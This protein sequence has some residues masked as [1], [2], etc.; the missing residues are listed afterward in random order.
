MCDDNST[1]V[2][3]ERARALLVRISDRDLNVERREVSGVPRAD[4]SAAKNQCPHDAAIMA[5]ASA[6]LA[7]E[8]NALPIPSATLHAI[9]AVLGDTCAMLRRGLAPATLVVG[10]MVVTWLVSDVGAVDIV[11]FLAYEIGF[12]ALPGAALLW[13]LRGRSWGFLLTIALGWPLGQT[14]EILAYSTTAA[15]GLRGLFL[16]YPVVV[17]AASAPFIWRRRHIG[18]PRSNDDALSSLLMWTAAAVL[19]LG[20]IYLALM[21]LPTVPLPST[22]GSVAYNP[23]YAYFLGLIAEVAHHWPATS[24]GLSGE[25]LHYQWF[26]FIHMAAINQVTNIPIPTIAFRLDYVPTII[27]LGCQLLAVGRFLGK[28]AWTGVLATAVFLLLG[29]LDLTTDVGGSTPFFDLVSNHL[30]A[31]W[32]FPYGLTFFLALIYCIDERLRA[33]TWR[34]ARD[35]SSWVLIG[36]LMIGGSGAKGTILPVIIAGLGLYF[37]LAFVVRRSIPVAALVTLALSLVI[38][39]VTFSVVY[40]GGVPGTNIQ[41]LASLARTAPVIVASELTSPKLRAVALPFAYVA[42]LAGMLLPLAGILYFLRRH[43]L[44][45]I[46]PFALCLCLLAAGLLIANVVHQV[47]YSELYFQD[48]GY[49]AGCIVAGAGLRLVW[50]DLGKALPISRRGV[51]I[52]LVVWVVFLLAVVAV[53]SRAVAHPDALKIRYIALAVGTVVFVLLWIYVLSGRRRPMAGVVALGLIPLL[54]AAALSPPLEVSTTVRNL[55]DDAPVTPVQPDPQTVW[56]LTPGLFAALRWL[57]ANAPVGAVL[58]VSNHWVDPGKTDGRY[59]YYSAFSERQVFIEGYDP[60]RYG[61]SD[62]LAMPLGRNYT[63]R[64]RL[65]DALFNHADAAALHVLVQQYGVR[66]LLVDR[67][68]GSV[69]TAVLQLG[70]IV[71]GDADAFIVAVG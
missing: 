9:P 2:S 53:T 30:L 19:S 56:G 64:Q 45:E 43:R 40:G 36:L 61:I 50:V 49:V 22:T 6:G 26:V 46:S 4:R 28:S 21:F 31:S 65:N 14:L 38:F 3:R 67:I 44:R 20:L 60:I 12:V 68:H 71:F 34:T 17:I 27:V 47:G 5:V 70:R 57:Q 25:P 63:Y 41:P 55:L 11:R 29:P 13:G 1:G 35:L 51:A 18:Q 62:V 48:T 59:F 66:F 16:L 52:A 32:T 15:T 8:C 69:D 54:A 7:A 33:A 42:G 23:D 37:V 24:P 10:V 39:A 58:A